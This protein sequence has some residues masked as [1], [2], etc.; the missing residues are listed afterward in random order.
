LLDKRTVVLHESTLW[1]WRSRTRPWWSGA[2]PRPSRCRNRPGTC[3]TRCRCSGPG[4]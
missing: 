3:P 2:P 4:A 1:A